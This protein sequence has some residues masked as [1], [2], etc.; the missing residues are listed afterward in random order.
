MVIKDLDL[1]PKVDA[2]MRDFLY[3]SQWKE[4]SKETSSKI[5]PCGDGSYR[6]TFK[7]AAGGVPG[8][9]SGNDAPRVQSQA[10][11]VSKD[12][13]S[14]DSATEGLE[15]VLERG[16]WMI[17]HIPL[18]L[19]KWNPSISL[20]KE[21]ITKVH[22]W[23]KTHKV[24]V[25]AYSEDGLSLIATQIGKPIMLDAFT[26]SICAES[27]GCVIFSHALIEVSTD[28]DLKNE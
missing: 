10:T 15:H 5:L 9:S 14:S 21:S 27:W 24:P 7:P 3:P 20:N 11:Y 19:T 6:K 13:V 28:L 2:M 25:V 16:P 22:V 1:E 8:A 18:I 4:L 26:S 12:G 17:R 23:V